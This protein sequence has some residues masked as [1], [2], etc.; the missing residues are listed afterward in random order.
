MVE[1]KSRR[2]TSQR[3]AVDQIREGETFFVNLPV[4]GRLEVPRPEQLAYYGG[5][6]ALAALELIDWPVALVIA[7][8][9]ILASNHHNKLLE[10]LGEAMEEI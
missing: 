4:I 1:K 10:E 6:A 3:E 5:L 2:D 7:A 8:G 9:H